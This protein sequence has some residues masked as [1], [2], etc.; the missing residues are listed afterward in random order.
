MKFSRFLVGTLACALMTA[1]SNEEN[2]AVDN[3]TQGQ[4]GSSYMA[5][6][7]VMSAETGSRAVTDGGYENGTEDE[8]AVKIASSVFLFYDAAGNYLTKG[9]IVADANN[10]ATS[11]GF[12]DLINSESNELESKS[13]AVIVL[14]PTASQS[15]QV[16][17]VLNGGNSAL[18]GLSLSQ[19][20]EQT[21]QS[22]LGTD[23]GSFLMTNSSYN[24]SLN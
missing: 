9:N 11:D 21:T 8:G 20:I 18:A 1:C 14:G 7:L 12:L 13:N 2:P 23:K 16:L 19:A 24:T 6:N 10:D 3:G 5:V 15:T 17:A 22:G 4:E